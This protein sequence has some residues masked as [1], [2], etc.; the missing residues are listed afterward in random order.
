MGKHDVV[1]GVYTETTA[2]TVAAHV[3]IQFPG[4]TYMD[5]LERPHDRFHFVYTPIDALHRVGWSK[6][7]ENLAKLSAANPE[8][9]SYPGASKDIL[10]ES[11]DLKEC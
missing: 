2:T 9:Y 3:K 1:I 4:L 7:P 11:E 6:V 10:F 5:L 8:H